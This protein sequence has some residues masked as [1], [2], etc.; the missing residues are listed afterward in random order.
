MRIEV[1]NFLY[2]FG[3]YAKQMHNLK[4]AYEKLSDSEKA[5]VMEHSPNDQLS[6]IAMDKLTFEWLST[7]RTGMKKLS[8]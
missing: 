2:E 6:P 3:N 7:M 5:L 1:K 4:D 8:D